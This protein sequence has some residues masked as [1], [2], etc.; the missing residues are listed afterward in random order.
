MTTRE[1]IRELH[2]ASYRR[3][4]ME[5]LAHADDLSAAEDAAREAFAGA[6]RN[7]R[8]VDAAVSPRAQ[9]RQRALD[10]LR[11]RAARSR[12]FA[13]LRR[14]PAA[15]GAPR[16]DRRLSEESNATLAA[17]V[18]LPSEQREAVVLHYLL[19]LPDD[20]IAEEIG[21]SPANVRTRLANAT[22]A[23]RPTLEAD[24]RPGRRRLDDLAIDLRQAIGM[25]PFEDVVATASRHRRRLLASV[26]AVAA[27]VAA[28]VVVSVGPSPDGENATSSLRR[29][30]PSVETTAVRDALAAPGTTMYAVARNQDG[31]AASFWLC[32]MCAIERSFALLSRDAFRH[33]K[34]VPLS[35]DGQG[36]AWAAPTGDFVVSSGSTGVVQV[37]SADGA[38][39][40]VRGSPSGRPR[41]AGA[42]D[43]VVTSYGIGPPNVPVVIDVQRSR[44]WPL[45][46]PRFRDPGAVNAVQSYRDGEDLWGLHLI[47]PRQSPGLVHSDDGGR[48]WSASLFGRRA[49]DPRRPDVSPF[50]RPL[51]SA[52]GAAGLLSMPVGEPDRPELLLSDDGIA[53]W[54]R[55]D[56][57]MDAAGRPIQVVDAVLAANGSIVVAGVGADQAS[58]VWLGTPRIASYRSLRPVLPESVR[59]VRPPLD[60]PDALWATA[61]RAIWESDDDGETWYLV[62]NNEAWQFVKVVGR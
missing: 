35:T 50:G 31:V 58:R 26:T 57:P 29:T 53:G 48:T 15:T 14:Q 46:I 40:P 3:L 38:V 27:L 45:S 20:E 28:G 1:L 8:A 44:L 54:H 21:A 47:G 60:R 19:E 17:V 23:L 61:P 56:A 13:A 34:V 12:L 32:R 59:F 25:P 49:G 10:V 52:S 51:V 22:A 16:A 42:E 55:R 2:E 43:L 37:V 9:V 11:R 4:A 7:G 39:R 33:V 36:E 18:A 6:Y 41:P 24:G 62:V 30:G 5:L